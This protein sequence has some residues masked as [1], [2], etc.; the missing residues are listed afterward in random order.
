[1]IGPLMGPLPRNAN[2]DSHGLRVETT[3][4]N[5]FPEVPI[6]F[7]KFGPKGDDRGGKRRRGGSF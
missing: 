4:P 2:L 5:A 6:P 1:M 7:N 3:D